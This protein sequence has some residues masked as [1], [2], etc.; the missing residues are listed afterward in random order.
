[1]LDTKLLH[2]EGPQREAWEL[3]GSGVWF[4]PEGPQREGAMKTAR[5]SGK[6]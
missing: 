5:V 2:G 3:G 1:M 6:P 4:T